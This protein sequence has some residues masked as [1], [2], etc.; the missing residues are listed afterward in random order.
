MTKVSVDE[1]KRAEVCG[2]TSDT[3]RQDIMGIVINVEL[4]QAQIK[5]QQVL[6]KGCWPLYYFTKNGTGGIAK[7]TYLNDDNGKVVTNFWL[8][9]DVGHTDEA[10]KELLSLFDGRAP[11]DTPKPTR[12]GSI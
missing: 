7:K 5:A 3:V 10:K 11:F 1:G 4:K 12:L 8:S 6:K 9:S 2:V